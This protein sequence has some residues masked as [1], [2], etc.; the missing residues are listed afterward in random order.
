MNWWANRR[1]R[2][3][4]LVALLLVWGVVLLATWRAGTRD[5]TRASSDA[6]AAAA[7]ASAA[8]PSRAASNTGR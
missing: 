3:L 2:L 1:V 4:L 8:A 6:A 7:P 5:A